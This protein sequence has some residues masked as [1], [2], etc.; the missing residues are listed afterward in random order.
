MR[1]IGFATNITA[2]LWALR[3][4]LILAKELGISQLV[5]EMD[6]I[7]IVGLVQLDKSPNNSYSA[8]LNDCRFLLCQLHRIKINHAFRKANRGVDYL[9]KG[10]CNPLCNF[11]VVDYPPMDKLCSILD[12]DAMGLYS[13][14]LSATTLSFIAS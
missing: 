7:V 3:D 9:A 14:R 8:L 12:F 5:V 11:V 13:L 10:G 2:E 4:G 1:H 6:A